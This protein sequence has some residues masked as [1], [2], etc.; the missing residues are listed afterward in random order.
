MEIQDTQAWQDATDLVFGDYGYLLDESGVRVTH[1]REF[2]GPGGD[3]DYHKI[4]LAGCDSGEEVEVYSVMDNN[5]R[6]GLFFDPW[7]LAWEIAD[8]IAVE[9]DGR[10]EEDGNSIIVTF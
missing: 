2:C 10:A 1:R 4:T 8:A 5:P 6:A 9:M 3:W 7:D